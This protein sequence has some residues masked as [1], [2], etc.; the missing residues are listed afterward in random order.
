MGKVLIACEYSG[1]MRD[2][3]I[4]QG[5]DAWSCD[6]LPTDV[7]GPHIQGD[8][9]EHLGAGWDLMIAHPPCTRLANSGVRW[10]HSPP[11]GKTVAEMQKELDEAAAFYLALR[12]APIPRKAIENPIMHRY[13]R[14]S[15]FG[16]APSGAA[17]LV[18]GSDI[19]SHRV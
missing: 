8:V 1:R 4:A 14:A 7:P 10:L 16:S 3:F 9:L 11:A 6:L 5:H 18:R 12:Y 17:A 13:A 19:Q 15:R 2:A